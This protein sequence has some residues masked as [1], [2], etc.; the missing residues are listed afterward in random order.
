M[1]LALEWR[2][3]R[4]QRERDEHTERER[5]RDEHTERERERD[6]HAE[7]ERDGLNAKP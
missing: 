6:E 5:E 1:I 7:R 3:A 2:R 4:I